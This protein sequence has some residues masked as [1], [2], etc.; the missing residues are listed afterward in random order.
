MWQTSPWAQAPPTPELHRNYFQCSLPTKLQQLPLSE[1]LMQ[2]LL[3]NGEILRVPCLNSP[4]L[5]QEPTL[6]LLQPESLGEPHPA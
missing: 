6:L 4:A 3:T 1:C 2:R 5:T